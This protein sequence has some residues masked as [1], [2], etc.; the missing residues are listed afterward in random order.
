MYQRFWE[1]WKNSYLLGLIR[2]TK[3]DG[4]SRNVQVGD[5]VIV[6]NENEPP[7]QWWMGR[8]KETYPG[9]DGLVRTVKL[10]YQGKDFIRPIT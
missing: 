10:N 3:W 8:I 9:K 7:T 6:K 5:I 4:S 2:R 1:T